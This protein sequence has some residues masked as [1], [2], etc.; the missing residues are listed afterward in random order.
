MCIKKL[1]QF[2]ILLLSGLFY[3]VPSFAQSTA[4]AQ[5]FGRV[6][7]DLNGNG[8]QDSGEPGIPNVDIIYQVNNGLFQATSTDINGDWFITCNPGVVVIYVDE[9]DVGAG[10]I[11]TEGVNP[12]TVIAT[13]NLSLAG[14]TD[15]YYFE[16]GLTGHLYFDLNG[17]GVQD[18][19]EPDM[20]N[21]DVIVTSS[22]GDQVTV[23]TTVTGDWSVSNIAIGTASV[24]V[25]TND[26]DFPTGAIQ[27]EGTNP[28]SAT[29]VA[30]QTTFTENDGFYE[31]GEITGHL[32]FDENGNGIQDAGEPDMPNVSILI[33]D[34]LG[35]SNY[36]VVTGPNGDWSVMVPAGTTEVEVDTS[37]PDFPT[38]AIQTEGTNPTNVLAVTGQTVFSENDGFFEQGALSGHLYFDKNGSGTQDSG[39]PDMPNVEVTIT[40][41]NGS[42]VTVSTTLTGDWSVSN[43]AIGTASVLVDTSDPDF[44]TGAVQTEGT[45]PS[46]ATVVAN[47]TTFTENDGWYEEGILTGHLYFDVNNNGVQDAGEPDLENIDV[48]ITDAL[49]NVFT[50]TTNTNGDWQANVPSGPTV[51]DIDENDPDFLFN[52]PQDITQGTDP[53]TT[54]VQT[55]IVVSEE[56]NGFF[57]EEELKGRL[58]DDTNGNGTQDAGEMGIPNVT[59]TLVD[60]GGNIY[61]TATVANGD[62]SL[63]VPVGSV[64]STIDENDPDFP[65]GAT[66]TEGTNPTTTNV[67]VGGTNT[68]IDGYT[69]NVIDTALISGHL[70]HD[71]NGN[72]TQDTG[73]P[74]LNDVTVE[75]T[76]SLNI[77]IPIKTGVNGD[78]SLLVPTGNTTSEI[79]ES[80][81]PFSNYVQTEGT[82]PTTTNVI[83]GGTNTEIDGYTTNVID[84]ALISGHLYHDLNGNGTQDTGEPDLNDVT[85]EITNSL[86]I[87]IPI[88]TG[89]NGDWSLLVPTGTTTSEINESTL[90]FSGAVQTEG[91]NPTTTNV[92][93]GGANFEID[94]YTTPVRNLKEIS[95]HV[96]KDANGNGVQDTDEANL[97]DVD[98]EITDVFGGTQ[99]VN[100]DV[101]GDWIANVAPGE[102]ISEINVNDPDFPVGAIQT[103]GTNPTTTQVTLTGT[104]NEFDGFFSPDFATNSLNGHVYF[105]TD[106][107]GTQD[108]GEINIANVEVEITDELGGI[109]TVITDMNG[110]WSAGVPV[111]QVSSEVLIHNIPVYAN[112]VISQGTNPTATQIVDGVDYNE[113]DGFTNDEDEIEDI[114]VFN[115]V[116]PNGDGKNDYLII[117]GIENFPDNKLMIFNR[118]GTKVYD[119]NSYGQNNKYFTG[120]SEG[121][122]T[123][124]EDAKLP[125]GTYFYMLE[126]KAN[127]GN[128]LKK[129]GYIY[130]N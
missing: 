106:G 17:N 115:A 30:N 10:A 45:N 52:I 53:T 20:P 98:V 42:P 116:S 11:Q 111:G 100:T 19:G 83:V 130:I 38:G 54:V 118:W 4:Q 41:S 35:S 55:G 84:T 82:N 73:E 3:S 112:V 14:G 22:S 114:E 80:T 107:D 67:T 108:V 104:F 85:V 69:T 88:K 51:S 91:T 129:Q 90:P 9:G 15:G 32:Y 121:K 89:V 18:S 66:Q 33:K 23:S 97:P 39:E 40:P 34:F 47:Q 7:K 128:V 63:T 96:Y 25:D 79:I 57:A 1:L 87:T 113:I 95:G 119:V 49:G 123:V 2:V 60:V 93:V 126:V 50:V 110:D 24:L 86:N 16:G 71:L 65:I 56:P 12:S 61:S 120:Y 36:T 103:E 46:S 37:D 76:N 44:P 124:K 105:D 5:L 122:V 92:T 6:Y 62:W 117:E 77:T 31:G 8:T 48:E 70:Y 59:V 72:G 101:N 27:T 43:I 28:S 94:G 75:I 64:T 81:L 102:T 78:W 99:T 29:V 109:Q 127:N 68:E 21:V 58:Y 26:P 125:A 74:D 13:A